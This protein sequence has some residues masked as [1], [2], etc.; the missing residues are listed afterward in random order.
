MRF[1]FNT[2]LRVVA[3]IS[4]LIIIILLSWYMSP[5]FVDNFTL[6]EQKLLKHPELYGDES[7]WHL[8]LAIA[9]ILAFAILLL[10]CLGCLS[11]LTQAKGRLDT[12]RKVRMIRAGERGVDAFGALFSCIAFIIV[13]IRLGGIFR[14]EPVC[15]MFECD[16][17]ARLIVV[18]VL[19]FLNTI[20][21][22]GLMLISM[23]QH[24]Y[25]Q[26]V[27]VVGERRLLDPHH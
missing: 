22:G 14:Y 25:F 20:L 19:Y 10:Q 18:A 5:N 2:L 4:C 6:A 21:F 11:T 3:L 7:H 16:F 1:V 12:P 24:E 15:G 8:L 9:C 23:H 27:E 26:V 13:V 17:R